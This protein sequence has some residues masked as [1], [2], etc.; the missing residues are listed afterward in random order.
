MIPVAVLYTIPEDAANEIAYLYNRKYSISW[1]EMGEEA[2]GQRVLPEDYTTLYLQF[3][4]AIHKLVPK[5]PLG[6]PAFEGTPA[7]VDSWSDPNGRVSFLGRF[8]DYLK[9]RDHL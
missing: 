5:A 4:K 8:V 7:D 3:A 9:A 6:G 2:D 1:I